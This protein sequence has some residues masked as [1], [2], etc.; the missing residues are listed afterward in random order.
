[1][2]VHW[3]EAMMMMRWMHGSTAAAV[4]A[5]ALAMGCGGGD[6]AAEAD[7]APAEGTPV[8]EEADP[9]VADALEE[10]RLAEQIKAEAVRTEPS[11]SAAESNP[12]GIAL[13]KSVMAAAGA[14]RLDEVDEI[15]FTFEVIDKGER[16]FWAKHRFNRRDRR[17]RISWVDPATSGSKRY[18]VVIDLDTRHV[19]GRVN[20][21]PLTD[22][23]R[24][25]VSELAYRRWVND[26]FWYAMPLKLRDPGTHVRRVEPRKIGEQEYQ[27]LHLFYDD[28]TGL[29]PDDIYYLYIDPKTHQVARW[30]MDLQSVEG[31][32]IEVDKDDY[33][34][35]GP[36]TL[37]HRNSWVD[38]SRVIRF[39]DTA[40]RDLPAEPEAFTFDEADFANGD[41][42]TTPADG[43]VD[44]EEAAP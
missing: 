8:A 1:M 5:M 40:V 21:E 18:D 42:P 11:A 34:K 13:A 22:E 26:Y 3:K 28:N 44:Q 17:D 38:G 20:G 25:K 15:Q 41:A 30:E 24:E 14:D 7:P 35:V 6:Q 16:T 10:A 32:P 31:D 43:A 36:L 33:R 9:A 29:T 27:V 23:Q 2:A 37:A 4:A 12:E 39:T 19:E